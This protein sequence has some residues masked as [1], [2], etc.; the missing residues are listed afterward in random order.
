M[1]RKKEK[2]RAGKKLVITWILVLLF[3]SASAY[4]YGLYYFSTHFLPGSMV[5][6]FNC[7]YMTASEAEE[8]L[9]K[10]VKAYALTIG[11]R[12]NGQEGIGAEEAGLTY[13]PS[14]GISRLLKDQ[15]RFIWF[16]AFHQKKSYHV[17]EDLTYDQEKLA[18]AVNGLDCMQAENVTQP[19][20]AQIVDQGEAFEIL[21]EV[22]GNALDPVKLREVLTKAMVTG[23]TYVNLEQEACYQKPY[24]YRD[25]PQL[26]QNC[27][28]MN[29][30]CE[31]VVTYDFADRTETVDR[32]V[33]K[34]WFTVDE[35][36]DVILDPKKVGEYVSGLGEKYDTFGKDRTFL[37]YDNRQVLVE[38]GDY[39][40]IIDQEK[41]VEALLQVIY[42]QKTQVRQPVYELWGYSRAENDI[43]YTYVEI[44]LTNQRLVFYQEGKPIVDTKIVTGNPNIPGCETPTGCFSVDDKKSPSVLTGED[45][46]AQ[47]SFWMPFSGNVGIHDAVWRT[48]F[49]GNLYMLEGSHGCVNVPY[50]QAEA[51]YSH[52]EAGMPVVVY[53]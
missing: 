26:I 9:S 30:L 28:R 5:N 6:G 52:I 20:D 49:G 51:I 32:S 42:S 31:I 36:G 22:E 44:D 11:T 38:G 8:L 2:M 35:N 25:D 12:N 13:Q 27:S 29:Q 18:Q 47:V 24:L 41:E 19:R 50:D 43:G 37:T 39:G 46:Q 16:L 3:L 53:K 40:W 48:E 10:K 17:E 15:D 33:I 14:G 23:E 4:A 21:P 1:A 45:Y 7:S 34:D